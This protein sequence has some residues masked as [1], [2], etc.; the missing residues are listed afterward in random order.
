MVADRKE[1]EK[2]FKNNNLNIKDSKFDLDADSK[3]EKDDT[4]IEIKSLKI[5]K[6]D[7]NKDT[8][9]PKYDQQTFTK[10]EFEAEY[11]G[12]IKEWSDYLNKNLKYPQEAITKKIKGTVVAQFI[13]NIDGSLSD[14]KI[15]ESPDKL[16]S[17][18]T[19]RIIKESGKWNAAVQNGRKVRA[20]KKQP[21]TFK[22][23]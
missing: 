7:E 14:I 9:Q 20:Y 15:V 1:T 11:P 5:V 22:L 6:L 13:V 18:E 8:V 12:G 3:I 10:V 21:I 4:V 23:S 2:Y 16:L 17:D 19:L